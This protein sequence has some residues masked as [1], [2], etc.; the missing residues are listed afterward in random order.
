MDLEIFCGNI[1]NK[2]RR[3]DY[4]HQKNHPPSLY[5]ITFATL[6]R[7]HFT[8]FNVYAFFLYSYC[9]SF[10]VTSSSYVC[11]LIT[12]NLL[13]L[14]MWTFKL[15]LRSL[16]ALILFSMFSIYSAIFP[17]S[18]VSSVNN[19][20]DES[21][22]CYVQDNDSSSCYITLLIDVDYN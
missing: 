18:C 7:S 14:I 15:G 13:L 16:I 5:S 4:H 1:Q 11:S 8:S 9:D 19:S 21:N 10:N 17:T 6:V 2:D 3:F 12:K 20:S 22:Y